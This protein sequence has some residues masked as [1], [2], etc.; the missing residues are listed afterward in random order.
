MKKNSSFFIKN[1]KFQDDLKKNLLKTTNLLR[2]IE[3]G[4]N[5]LSNLR[6]LFMGDRKMLL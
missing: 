3:I 4:K 6:K 1:N 2:I 5:K